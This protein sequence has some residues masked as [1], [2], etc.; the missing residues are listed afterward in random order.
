MS[1]PEEMETPEQ[2]VSLRDVMKAVKTQGEFNEKLRKD[3]SELKHEV[4]GSTVAVASQ[5]KK[6]KTESQYIW[7]YE[8]NKVQFLLNTEFLEDLTQAIWAI[9]N[10]KTDY[11][12]ETITEV[13]DKIKRRNKLV[14][15]ADSSEGGWET[16]RQYESNPVASNSDDENKINKAES[17]A[18]RKRNA[19]GKKSAS[20]KANYSAPTRADI[21]DKI[22]KEHVM[23]VDRSSTG[24]ASVPSIPDLSSQNRNSTDFIKDEYNCNIDYLIENNT[25]KVSSISDSDNL[26]ND[27]YEYEQGQAHIIVKDRLKSHY[28]FWKDIGCYDY[29][30]DTILNGYKIPFYSTPPSV[31]LKN[32]R[33]AIIHSEFVT[34]AIHD[35]LIRG[36]IEECEFQPRVV[37]PLT[38]S[39]SDGRKKR[40]ILDL[41]HVNKHLWKSSVKFEDVRIAMQFITNNSFCFQF[42]IVS[43]YH[44]VNIFMPHTEFL[45][46][47][48]RHENTE[49]WYKFLVLPFGLSSACYIFTKIT[50]PLIKKWRGE[51]KQVLMYLD[52]GLGTHTDEETCKTMSNQVRQDL[53]QSGFVPK[54]EKSKWSPMKLLVF[55]GYSIDTNRGTITIPNERVQKVL[56]TIADVEYYVSKHGKVHARLVAS[57]VGQIVSMSYVIGNVAYIMSK[58]L[59]IDI[60]SMTSWNS[61]IVLSTESLIQIKFWREN[62]EHVNVKKFSSDVSCQSVVYSDAS[63]TGYGGYVV[64]TPFNIAHGMW[65]ECEASKSSTWKELNA[66]RNILLSMINVLKDKRIK[67]FSDNQNVVTIVEK[68]SMKPELQDIAMCIFENCLIHNISIDVVWVPRTLNEKADFISRIIDYDDWGIDEQLFMYVDSLWGPHEIDWFAND[69]NHKLTVFYSRYWTV[70]SMGIDA[71]TINWQG[72]NG[73]FVPPVCLVSKVISYMRQCFAHGTLVLP[74]WKS[75][76]FWPMLCPTGEGFIKEV[77]GCIDLPTN[78]KFYTSG[79]GNKSAFQSDLLELPDTLIEK[80][81]LL[82]DLLTESKSNNTVQ[83]YYYGFLRWKK[84]ALSNGISSEFILPAK[85]IHVA[86]YLACL[87]QQNRTPS[88]INQAFYSIRWAH[89]IISVISPTDSDLVKNILE[90]AKR[91]LSVPIKKKEPITPDMLSQMFDRAGK[92]HINADGLSRIPDDIEACRNYRPDVNLEE[93][94]CG[95]CKFCTRAR[96]QWQTFEEEVD[97]VVPLTIRRLVDDGSYNTNWTPS[98]SPVELHEEQMKDSDLKTLKR[99]IEDKYEPTKAELKLCSEVVR[100]FW[101]LRQQIQ[102]KDNILLYKWEDP[103]SPR[104]LFMTPKQMQKELLHGCHDVVSSGHM[105]QYKTLEKLKQIAVWLNMTQS[106]KLMRNQLMDQTMDEETNEIYECPIGLPDIFKENTNV[107]SS[108]DPLMSHFIGDA[109]IVS[110]P[111]PLVSHTV[112][113]STSS[114]NKAETDGGEKNVNSDLH[115]HEMDASAVESDML[116]RRRHRKKP[117]YLS[118]YVED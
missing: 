117:A 93:L 90:G 26:T 65:S 4:H 106:C 15:I 47:S 1:D 55:L 36:L 20:K 109:A 9:D 115:V 114:E 13:I 70:N 97:F 10:S 57:L 66:V 8:G 77:K 52:D 63:N 98:Y 37:N 56:K 33:S 3:I 104:L 48:W 18:I 83:N 87:V 53:I 32:N 41:R 49:K 67:W 78:K 28:S 105:G 2:E 103:I 75:A 80:I 54:N 22:D 21:N 46:F 35:L 68:G 116:S 59:S 96:Q 81:H 91:R 29:I 16:V 113:N 74:L 60:L 86:I 79:K 85:P 82:P 31:C 64:E 99:W 27:Y 95:G 25:T 110:A 11:A 108:S 24:E 45:G 94:P 76:S 73:W 19:K 107:M 71:F 88:P 100:H 89:K 50:R 12:R 43:A 6:L 61:C 102:I 14:K 17:R 58:H 5:V 92:K 111:D 7:K 44:H 38:V 23:V 62:L 51:G 40:L 39:A 101:S 84:W 69:D 42:D 72:A 118:D 34:E 112:S 30:L